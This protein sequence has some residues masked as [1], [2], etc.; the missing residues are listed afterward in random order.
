MQTQKTEALLPAF[1]PLEACVLRLRA[2]FERRGFRRVFPSMFEDYALYLDN[3]N[4]L[5]AAWVLTFMDPGGRLL[6]IKPDV[7]LSIAKGVN[8]A[9]L[10]CAE[11]LYYTDE[12]VRFSPQNGAYKVMPQIGLEW[13][14]AQDT[15]AN[16]EVV[17]LALRSL[18]LIGEESAVD[19]SHMAFVS[20]LLEDAGL[21]PHLERELLSA[22]HAKS[23][24]SAAAL[25]DSAGVGAPEKERILTLADLHG[26]FPK[27]LERAKTLVRGPRMEQAF[28]ELSDLAEIIQPQ[29][30]QTVNLDFSVVHDLD[31]YNGLIFR[32]YI[33]GIPEVVC[34]GGRYDNLMKKLGK[35][36][37]AV[38]F[39]VYLHRLEGYLAR[40]S[41]QTDVLITYS[42]PCDWKALLEKTN[43]F[44][45]QGLTVRCAA[46]G[47]D[48]SGISHARLM[49]FPE[50]G[51][52]DA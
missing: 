39:A 10:A 9:E 14:G 27:E 17:D 52:T 51:G 34:G 43:E 30:G 11:K 49:R 5:G 31:Y 45:A 41:R 8:E 44:N 21:S 38:G 37:G 12:V 50:G 23:I 1:F 35:R 3:K 13:I 20:G 16:L 29:A 4:F 47:S 42:E 6:A 22:I 28:K 18:A 15:F 26:P 33:K 48:I 2:L 36:S 24:H 25:L 32:G 46:Q 7:T 19:I 40:Y